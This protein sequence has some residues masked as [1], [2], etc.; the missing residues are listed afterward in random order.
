MKRILALICVLACLC[1]LCLPAAAFGSITVKV[2]APDSW[3]EVYLYMWDSLG[4]GD[5]K[6]CNAPWPGVKLT[7]KSGGWYEVKVDGVYDSLIV[8]NGQGQT[9]DIS[10]DALWDLWITVDA[11]FNFGVAYNEK[12]A[13]KVDFGPEFMAI[14][15]QNITGVSAWN[16][17]DEAGRMTEVEDLV[18]E[19]TIGLAAGTKMDFKFAGNGTWDLPFNMGAANS[20]EKFE[21]KKTY[22]LT[23]NGQDMSFT[24]SED[25]GLKV[26]LDLNGMAN[27]G[28][29]TFKL[30]K[31]GNVEIPEPPAPVEKNYFV[32]GEG[33]LCGSEWNCADEANKMSKV[34][35]GVYSLTFANVAAG[36]YKLKV[37]DGS[38]SNCWGD[39]NSGDPDGNFIVNVET[40]GDVIVTFNENNQTVSVEVKAGAPEVTE[41]SVEPS[42]PEASEPEASE[43]SV[44]P[45]QPEASEPDDAGSEPGASEPTTAPSVPAQTEAGEDTTTQG[46]AL[47][48]LLAVLGVVIILAVVLSIPKKKLK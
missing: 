25:M 40:A 17:G 34:S 23:E 38:W 4:E 7:N 33:T 32:A 3:S 1:A 35:D 21:L 45:S 46:K 16:P 8:S 36:S 20:G 26:T 13:G 6:P 30:E 11:G 12:D 19:I 41:P 5:E 42:E 10:V 29:A 39:A 27:G 24:A 48:I 43:P 14:V 9:K 22:E 18:Y 47:L 28:K 31:V 15:G 44:A 2:K 37:T